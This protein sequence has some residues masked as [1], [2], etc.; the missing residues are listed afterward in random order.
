MIINI[1]LTMLLIQIISSH[2]VCFLSP[3][4]HGGDLCVTDPTASELVWICSHSTVVLAIIANAWIVPPDAFSSA[5]A[6][7]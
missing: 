5:C 1:L 6:A 4:R 3:P 7:A 2:Q